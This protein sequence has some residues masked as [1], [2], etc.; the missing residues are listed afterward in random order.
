MRS[1][2]RERVSILRA[3]APRVSVVVSCF[4]LGSTLEEALASVEAQTLRDFEILVVDDG[5]RDPETLAVLGRIPAERARVLRTENRG[6]PAAR[7]HGVRF[8]GGEYVCCLDADDR[9]HPEW[10]AK[11]VACLDADP[12]LAFASHWLRTFGDEEGDWKPTDCDFPALLDMNTVNGAALV[13]R[14]VWEA[15]GGQD[16]TLR[17]G[18]EDWDFWITLV[19]RGQ[20]GTILPEI[21]FYYRR[22]EGSMSH[23]LVGETHLRVYRELIE[24]HPETFARYLP[25]LWLRRQLDLG[26]SLREVHALEVEW[27]VWLSARLDDRRSE[28]AALSRPRPDPLLDAK[29]AELASAAGRI[30]ELEAAA[31]AR[32][33]ELRAL[34]S[35]LEAAQHRIE[36]LAAE[37]AALRASYSWR[38]TRPLRAV[39]GVVR[40]E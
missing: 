17:E 22:R 13:R 9:L 27:D 18:C 2:R 10:L 6:L 1:G 33:Q 34:G 24:R 26:R 39:V 23:A 7:N 4:D 25:E 8:A 35:G 16:E 15:V 36:E 37:V 14:S 31:A 11:A 32:E 40:G 19:E 21:L 5:S 30:S 38:L 12:G 28:A 3:M 20:R 29:R